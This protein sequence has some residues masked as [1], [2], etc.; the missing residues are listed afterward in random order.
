MNINANLVS[1]FIKY[2]TPGNI[3]QIL[4]FVTRNKVPY[5]IAD[6]IYCIVLHQQTYV[7][8][9][10]QVFKE[11]T[12]ALDMT[13]YGFSSLLNS[14]FMGSIATLLIACTNKIIETMNCTSKMG[15]E[16]LISKWYASQNFQLNNAIF[17]VSLELTTCNKIQTIVVVIN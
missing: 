3:V 7:E 11:C 13:I 8:I 4:N 6:V 16:Y 2:F 15:K 5:G 12:L 17:F 14:Q 9:I 10:P 1:C